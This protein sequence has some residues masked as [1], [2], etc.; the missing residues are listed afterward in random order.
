MQ[1][2]R[3]RDVDRIRGDA[4]LRRDGDRVV[5]VS[6]HGR[7]GDGRGVGD[8]RCTGRVVVDVVGIFVVALLV[9]AAVVEVGLAVGLEV[10]GDVSG[11]QHLPAHVTGHLPLVSDHVGAQPVFGREGRGARRYLALEGPL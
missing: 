5:G 2:D 3:R 7:G 8:W 6:V 11:T 4:H 10:A 9:A 1:I